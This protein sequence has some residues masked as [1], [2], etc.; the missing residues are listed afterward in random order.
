MNALSLLN[1]KIMLF[2]VMLPVCFSLLGITESIQKTA[3]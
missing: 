2:F 1:C 3:A